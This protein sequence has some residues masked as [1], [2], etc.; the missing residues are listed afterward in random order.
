LES[1]R[2]LSRG[3]EQRLEFI[4][5][6]LFWDG[7]VNRRDLIERFG[8]SVPQ[9]SNDLT[10]YRQRAPENV[11]YDLSGKRYVPTPEFRPRFLKPNP[12]RYL[13]QLKALSDGILELDDTWLA[14]IPET[15]VLPI[16]S[17]RSDASVLRAVLAAIRSKRALH[18]NYQSSSPE[19][20]DPL[21]RWIS[22]HA[23]GFDGF[24]WHV[25]AFCHRDHRFKDFLLGRCLAV[26][27]PGPQAASGED[28]WHWRTFFD[29]VLQPNPELTVEQ[30]Q[31]IALDYNMTDDILVV[32]V[33]FAL[34][35]YFNKRL[36]FDVSE[37]YDKP[38]ERP[39]TIKN[40]AEFEAALKKADTP[41][42]E[43][44]HSSSTRA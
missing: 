28:D 36:R 15:G 6:R 14:E 1:D 11:A 23:F 30:R 33:R 5:F 22:P 17:R 39:V 44:R 20:P 41:L 13:A 27:E 2:R 10:A 32:P 43:G 4:E 24:R 42:A 31:A 9:A 40:K 35:Y 12:D 21:W 18:I 7:G 19:N 3:A 8:V 29:V 25:R 34:L 16:P 26:S 37:R 38:R